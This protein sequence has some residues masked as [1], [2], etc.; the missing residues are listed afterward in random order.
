MF[1]G[2]SVWITRACPKVVL[3]GRGN[4]LGATRPIN[5]DSYKRCEACMAIHVHPTV[6]AGESLT[7]A[8]R[9]ARLTSTDPQNACPQ[10]ARMAKRKVAIFVAYV[11]S[12][13]RGMHRLLMAQKEQCA[14][15]P[16]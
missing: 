13:F 9:S 8:A 1:T 4:A 14:E 2:V 5:S 6:A 16:G 3:R 12:A 10:Q 11:G 7:D 15:T